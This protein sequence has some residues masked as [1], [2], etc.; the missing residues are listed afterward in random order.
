MRGR[1]QLSLN[2]QV[3]ATYMSGKPVY[4]RDRIRQ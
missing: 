3:L 1:P 2:T 4:E